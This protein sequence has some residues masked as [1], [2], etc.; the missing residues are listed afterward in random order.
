MSRG[1]LIDATWPVV[2]LVCPKRFDEGFV[3]TLN[4][5]FDRIFARRQ[6]FAL[7]TDTRAIIELPK[8]LERKL[9]AEWANR[10][11]QLANTKTWNAGSATILQNA[12]MR[13]VMQ[14]LYWIWTPASPQFAAKDDADSL[15]WCLELLAKEGIKPS[16]SE[17]AMR[18]IIRRE[19]ARQGSIIPTAH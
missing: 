17:A 7:I 6:R 4:E 18:E 5:D 14:G 3:K 19:T 2:V 12:I 1:H 16:M 11:D 8:P 15:T 10:P 13:T 9:L